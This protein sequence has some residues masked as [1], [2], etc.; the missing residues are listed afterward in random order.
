MQR[1]DLKSS[2]KLPTKRPKFIESL[3][4]NILIKFLGDLIIFFILKIIDKPDFIR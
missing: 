2:T 3:L 1:I 4:V